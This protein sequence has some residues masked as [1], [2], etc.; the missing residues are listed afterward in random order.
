MI[1]FVSDV[2][3]I[4]LCQ[5]SYWYVCVRCRNNM[6][7]VRCG[8]T[9]NTDG[10][11]MWRWTGFNAGLD[12]IVTYDSYKLTL[13]RSNLPDH[14][15]LTS[16]HKNRH[17]AYRYLCSVVHRKALQSTWPR[18]AHLNT[19]EQ[20]HCLQVFVLCSLP[21]K[22]C[23]L[24]DHEALTSTHKNRHIAYRYL[25]SVVYPWSAAI[26]LTT[27]RSPQHTRTGTLPTGI[28]AL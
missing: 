21:V 22:R 2:V 25:C 4:C 24:P 26:Y 18:G 9:L 1:C 12:L 16:T 19:Q 8:R 10:Q 17:I 5:M 11:H 15:A 28:C 3:L 7:C 20:A 27:R 13:K 23:N 14:E 6:F